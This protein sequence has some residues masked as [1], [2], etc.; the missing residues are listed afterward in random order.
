MR[1]NS[2][3]EG[4]TEERA[5]K[6][7][8]KSPESVICPKVMHAWAII[9]EV[10]RNWPDFLATACCKGDRIWS[11]NPAKLEKL[12]KHTVLFAENLEGPHSRSKNYMPGVDDFLLDYDQSQGPN[13]IKL[14]TKY[15][16][17]QG[18]VPVI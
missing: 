17:V 18:Y 1:G 13:L 12:G 5:S 6:C 16:Q 15:L 2:R 9:W 8:Y 14:K 3:D 11:L 7:M 4:V 10:W